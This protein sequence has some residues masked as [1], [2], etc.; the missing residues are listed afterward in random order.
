M[1]PD[2]AFR[3]IGHAVIGL[4][5]LTML[6]ATVISMRKEARTDEPIRAL[7][8]LTVAV[9]DGTS[10]ALASAYITSFQRLGPRLQTQVVH[11]ADPQ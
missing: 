1:Q 3:G 8:W 2:L 6:V 9:A 4:L 7:L 5:L 11:S 10:A